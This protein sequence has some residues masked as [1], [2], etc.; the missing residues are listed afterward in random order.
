MHRFCCLLF[1]RW[2]KTI[3]WICVI[4]TLYT[5]CFS[6]GRF[7]MIFGLA[8]LSMEIFFS[9]VT[10][11]QFRLFSHG[12]IRYYAVKIFKLSAYISHGHC[13]RVIRKNCSFWWIFPIAT[14]WKYS[15]IYDVSTPILMQC[16]SFFL[17]GWLIWWLGWLT[18]RSNLSDKSYP[19][20][21]P[22]RDIR[23]PSH[24]TRVIDQS[25]PVEL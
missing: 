5:G 22:I 25:I 24:F 14:K 3:Q 19:S 1:V 2:L 23:R 18:S 13:C 20:S 7:V 12:D 4:E 9:I 16:R 8:K 17:F 6:L 21:A 11:L 15:L 10:H